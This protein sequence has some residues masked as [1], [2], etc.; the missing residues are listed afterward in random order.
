[1]KKMKIAVF[2]GLVFTINW[3]HA[4]D[5]PS[6]TVGNYD[7]EKGT[8]SMKELYMDGVKSHDDVKLSLDFKNL[9]FSVVSGTAANNTIPDSAVESI[10]QDDLTVGLRGCESK[11]KVTTCHFTVTSHGQDREVSFCASQGCLKTT[12]A[13][14]RLHNAYVASQITLANQSSTYNI[15]D[16]LLVAGV[17]V[18]ASAEFSNISPKATH[19]TLMKIE[20]IN[21]TYKFR[22]VQL[23]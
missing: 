19:F 13:L 3:A 10:T 18:T 7:T 15:R 11:N 6:Y 9:T 17:P 20:F 23:N 16:F 22:N 5:N 8:L 1:M 2:L 21:K 4:V 12:E 14:D